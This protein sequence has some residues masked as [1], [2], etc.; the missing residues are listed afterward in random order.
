MKALVL[1]A[2]IC[3]RLATTTFAQYFTGEVV[4]SLK[5]IPKPGVNEDSLLRSQPGNSSVYLIGDRHY[6]SSY[7]RDG[8]HTYSY[9]YHDESRRMYD[10]EEDK[11]YLTWRDSRKGNNTLIRSTIYRDS[12]TVVLG[13][14]CYLVEYTYP[15]HISK[16]Y[17]TDNVRINYES[18]KGHEVGNWYQIMKE[19]KGGY[20]MKTVTIFQTHIEIQEVIEMKKRDVKHGEFD[21]P[22]S[23][24]VVASFSVL[25]GQAELKE[26]TDRLINCYRYNLQ[27]APDLHARTKSH[28]IYVRFMLTEKG[29]IQMASAVG[30]DEYGLHKLAVEIIT[31]CGFEFTPGT[32]NNKPVSSEVY[33]PIEFFL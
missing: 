32:I 1:A 7:F 33:F 9:T 29:E 27:K 24:P 19:V 8:K 5:T 6:K 2:L 10:E 18:F 25:D 17:Y 30:D 28:T 13:Y 21:L 14:P 3:T 12:T 31:T 11:P 26:P 16:T 20:G 23:K 15:D 4:Y 22:S